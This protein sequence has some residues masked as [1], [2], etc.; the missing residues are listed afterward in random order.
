MEY[1]KPSKQRA[2]VEFLKRSAFTSGKPYQEA[3]LEPQKTF[4][5][6]CE[7]LN[8]EP[9]Y[10][11]GFPVPSKV[12]LIEGGCNSKTALV[13]YALSI[14]DKE[15]YIGREVWCVFDFDI[16]PDEAR[17]QANDF[18]NAINKAEKNGLKVAWSND[19][20]ELWF[21]LHFEN[22]DARL[23]RH[24]IYPILKERWNLEHFDS[25]AKTEGFCKDHYGR[26]GGNGQQQKL[27]MSRA[28]R[29]HEQYQGRRDFAEQCPCTTVYLLVEQLNMNLKK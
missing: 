18:N 13:D 10:F 20:F 24:Q 27:A 25:I 17:T 21:L 3:T 7:G 22:I 23:V 2:N 11:K 8:T 1:N 5:I 4:L 9:C 29:L 26:H 12:V 19:A 28:K 15:E 16:H 14:R 6:I